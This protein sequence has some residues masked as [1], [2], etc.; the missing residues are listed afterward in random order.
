MEKTSDNKSVKFGT[1]AGV[2]TPSILTIFGVIMFMRANF[3]TGDAGI[4][5]ALAQFITFLT[6]FSVGAIST[7]MQVEGGGAYYMVS[8]VLGAEFGGAIGIALFLAQVISITFYLLGFTEAITVAFPATADYFMYIGLA[9]AI[10]L[11][12]IARI[13]ADWAIKTQYVI[14]AV[15]FTSIFIYL[16]GAGQHFSI[17]TF[18]LN[19]NPLDQTQGGTPFW[20]LFAIYFPSVTGFIAGINMSGDLE[21]PGNNMLRGTIYSL[22]VASSVYGLQILLYGGAFSRE[23]LINHPFEVMKNNALFGAG[24]MVIA[25]VCAATLSSALGRF[26]GA[27]R[28][29]RQ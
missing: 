12:A 16:V 6:T 4:I 2:F 8:R 14:M 27:P 22:L 20:S 5:N 15:L 23:E 10:I 25:G 26:V 17:E 19:L 1:F 28:F 7:N 29:Y 18:K 21:D 13:G 24:F 11:F 9:A 3:V